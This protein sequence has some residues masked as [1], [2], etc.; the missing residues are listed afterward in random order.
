MAELSVETITAAFAPVQEP[1][2]EK[3]LLEAGLLTDIQVTGSTVALTLRLLSPA[4]PHLEEMRAA[5]T[6][7]AQSVKGVKNVE[8]ATVL[9]VPADPRLQG[10][11]RSDI[12]SVIAVASGKG[13]VGKSTVAVNIAVALAQA[14]ASVGL[15]DA[16]V[17]GPNIPLMMGVT[18]LPPVTDQTNIPPAVAH[19]V[20][21]MSIGFMVK[22]EQ[23]IVWRGPMLHTAIRQFVQDV[24]WGQLDYLVVDLPPGTGDAQ[25]SLAQT[26]SI[27]GGLIVTLPQAVSLEDARRGLEMFRQLSVPILGVVEN[28]SFLELPD[29]SRMDVFGSSGGEKM[30]A[31]AAVDFIGSIPLDPAVRKGGDS[32]Q[33][34]V[35]GQPESPVAVA[36][37]TI[38]A[39]AALRASILALESQSNTVPI[40]IVG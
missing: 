10:V 23:P 3:S 25:L 32:G 20:K 28:M 21:L 38:A 17:Y 5:L 29:G 2:L 1:A 8:I 18:G 7:A 4:H 34:I 39:E 26:V 19:G 31:E 22:K 11:G 15:L 16:D 6:A 33:P 37:R 27:T 36:L 12:K 9:A 35:V 24:A 14:G 13:G 40:S 30:A